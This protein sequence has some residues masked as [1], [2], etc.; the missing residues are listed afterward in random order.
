ML[1]KYPDFQV[2]M[3]LMGS[4]RV[5]T[6]PVAPVTG[7]YMDRLE[8]EIDKARFLEKTPQEALDTVQTDIEREY[9]QWKEDHS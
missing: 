2:F 9:N 6:A 7:Q 5:I 8:A 3:D 4:P 1:A